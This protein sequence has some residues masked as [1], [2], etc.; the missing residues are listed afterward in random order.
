MAFTACS[1]RRGLRSGSPRRSGR[2]S[3]T[4]PPRGPGPPPHGGTPSRPCRSTRCSARWTRSTLPCS[5]KQRWGVGTRDPWQNESM[6]GRLLD[7]VRG[8]LQL[9]DAPWRIALALAVVVAAVTTYFVS[10][11][12]LS[13]RRRRQLAES[14]IRQQIEPAA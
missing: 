6:V 10:L 2:R 5:L 3:T 8:L 14:R 1:C 9:D 11:G 13:W 12:A 7:R 4:P